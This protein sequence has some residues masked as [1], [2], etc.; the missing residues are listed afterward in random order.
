VVGFVLFAG[1]RGPEPAHAEA[2]LVKLEEKASAGIKAKEADAKAHFDYLVDQIR[3]DAQKTGHID[4]AGAIAVFLR[5]MRDALES[6]PKMAA[7]MDSMSRDMSQMN[8]KMSGV[9]VMATEMQ[10][11]NMLMG[12]MAHGVDSTMGRMG[13][14][15]P[16]AP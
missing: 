13:N 16:W 15:M 1:L 9:P 7:D 8:G 4:P 11:M 5:D 14:W 12:V 3:I 2:G 6:M 10:H